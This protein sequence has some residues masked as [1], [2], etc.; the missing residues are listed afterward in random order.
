MA[1]DQIQTREPTGVLCVTSMTVAQWFLL[2]KRPAA[3][4]APPA[5]V[6]RDAWALHKDKIQGAAAQMTS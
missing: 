1:M 2:S 6:S 5:L 3:L 4:H